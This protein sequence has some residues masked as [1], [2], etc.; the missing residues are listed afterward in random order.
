MNAPYDAII[1]EIKAQES[2]MV[3]CHFMYESRNFN[4]EAH[5]LAKHTPS[6]GVGRYILLDLPYD[7]AIVPLNI[8]SDN[9]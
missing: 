7:P 9:Q 1:Q 4:F 6:L 5:S 3:S 2:S 8:I